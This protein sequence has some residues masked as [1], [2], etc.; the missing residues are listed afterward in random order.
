MLWCVNDQVVRIVVDV[1]R[2]EEL[3]GRVSDGVGPRKEFS[4]WLGLIAAL[5]AMIGS[6]G[7]EGAVADRAALDR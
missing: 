1:E 2:G 5:D 4:G 7:R 6:P 3:R